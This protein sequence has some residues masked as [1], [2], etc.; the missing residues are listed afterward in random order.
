M[1]VSF[2]AA[3]RLGALRFWYFLGYY[4]IMWTAVL[5]I[6]MLVIA[7]GLLGVAPAEASV[8]HQCPAE[9]SQAEQSVTVQ[10]AELRAVAHVLG[11]SHCQLDLMVGALTSGQDALAPVC[12]GNAKALMLAG[13]VDSPEP[14][15]PRA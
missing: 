10:A 3:D 4:P 12:F 14:L 6:L 2:P 9:A 13:Y 7:I 15:P 5:R 11:Q 1:G 8:R